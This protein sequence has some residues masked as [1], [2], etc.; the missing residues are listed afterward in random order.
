MSQDFWTPSTST[1]AIGRINIK[2]LKIEPLPGSE[3]EVVVTQNF[4]G[5][6]ILETEERNSIRALMTGVLSAAMNR[7]APEP[8]RAEN[9][10]MPVKTAPNIPPIRFLNIPENLVDVETAE[11]VNPLSL[12]QTIKAELTRQV[13]WRDAIISA[14]PEITAEMIE[15]ALKASVVTTSEPDSPSDNPSDNEH[16]VSGEQEH[17]DNNQ[18]ET[19]RVEPGEATTHPSED[20]AAESDSKDIKFDELEAIDED[21][22][23]LT[24]DTEEVPI[25]TE[26]DAIQR[27][28]MAAWTEAEEPPAEVS[29]TEGDENSGAGQAINH[30]GDA[31]EYEYEDE[32]LHFDDEDD[33]GEDLDE[34]LSFSDEESEPSLS[35]FAEPETTSTPTP[36]AP[37]E[38]PE[39]PE[40]ETSQTPEASEAIEAE[41]EY[42]VFVLANNRGADIGMRFGLYCG[43]VTRAIGI[44]TETQYELYKSRSGQLV[45]HEDQSKTH[46][47]PEDD[48]NLLFKL[49][50]YREDAKKAYRNAEVPCIRWID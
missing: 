49:L 27:P 46:E 36:E 43:Q 44:S 4:D 33:D 13:E 18:N 26:E 48:H 25:P 12:S 2:E 34:G 11:R 3:L 22:A 20:Q 16:N 41:P 38:T 19:E 42:K 30:E 6:V 28:S 7:N 40:P 39:E 8:W 23:H 17:G 35:S 5:E 29:E 10:R 45:V 47:I 21:L 15:S 9:C 31:G 37:V 50:G 1:P 32:L 24:K 14:A